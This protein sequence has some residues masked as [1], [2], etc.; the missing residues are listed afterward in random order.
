MFSKRLLMVAAALLTA[1]S[2]M[3]SDMGTNVASA[4]GGRGGG[5]RGG[6]GYRGGYGGYRGGGWGGRG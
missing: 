1:G 6:A 2:V 4:R 5:Y 3:F